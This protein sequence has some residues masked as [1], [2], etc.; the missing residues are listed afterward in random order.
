[1]KRLSTSLA[2]LSAPLVLAGCNVSLGMSVPRVDGVKL[3]HDH[4]ET[5]EVDSL[6]EL[7]L[8]I[9]AA[10]GD[11]RVERGTGRTLVTVKVHEKT[12]GDASVS[13]VDGRLVAETE[14]GDPAAI[15][16][17]TVVTEGPIA[18]LRFATG[19]G[20]IDVVDVEITGEIRL[21]TG[22]GDVRLE[23]PGRP[24]RVT[25][26]SGK[27]DIDCADTECQT[28]EA[29]SGM[30]D[31]D[32]RSVEA[33]DADLS[34]GF[35]DIELAQCTFDDLDANTGFGDIECHETSYERGDLN[36]GLGSVERD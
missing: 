4:L 1:M 27:G 31:I 8:T 25:L 13:F 22:L 16:E 29:S 2:L 10:I 30:G 24:D 35:G 26:A 34:S 11:L 33:Q 20:D 17:V 6:A 21:E 23:R 14:S 5:L 7:G 28:L 32:V 12:P 36:T 9:D 15:G 19:L 3:P 18:H